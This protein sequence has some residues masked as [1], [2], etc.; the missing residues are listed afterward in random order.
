MKTISKDGE[1]VFSIREFFLRYR[2][3]NLNPDEI[4]HSIFIPFNQKNE[5]VHEYKQ[6][7]RRE[8]D[9][10]IVTA[11]IKV[12][13]SDLQIVENETP[14][15]EVKEISFGYGGMAPKTIF[16]PITEETLVGKRWNEDIVAIANDCLARDLPLADNAP[17][18]MIQ[19]R[20][21]LTTSFFFKFYLFVTSQIE[22]LINEALPNQ[23]VTLISE[24]ELSAI[25]VRE[26]P[27]SGGTQSF[28][29]PDAD[30]KPV[31]YPIKHLAADKQVTGEAIY[32]VDIPDPHGCLFAAYVLS[33]KAHAKILSI[34]PSK[35]LEMKGVVAFFSAKDVPKNKYSIMFEDEEVFA[36]ELSTFVGKPIG[37]I[38]AETHDIATEAAKLVQA[39]YEEF[40]PIIT[41]EQAIAKDSF[42]PIPID[43]KYGDIDEGF[44]NS[45]HIV[46]GSIKTG[47]Q[48]HFYLE[49]HNSLA[50]PFEDEIIIYSSTQNPTKNQ[51]V[52]A[53]VLD[54]PAHRV[55]CICKRM[56]GG[57][58]GKET[59]PCVYSAVAA[60]AATKLKRAVRLTLD[61]DV[62]MAISGLRHPFLGHYKVGFNDDGNIVAMETSLYSNAGDTYDLSLPVLERF[63]LFLLF[64]QNRLF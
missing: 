43:I 30:L 25:A 15:C 45:K 17:G 37:L 38:V 39:S 63:E 7:R 58:G 3:V 20:K 46:E 44:K 13:L 42:Y 9:I 8:D 47:A 19:F 29:E 32:T 2:V 53:K 48:D 34:D 35:A 54:I 18:G 61:R 59:K 36:S 60:F 41:I 14:Y 40:E 12:V 10:A 23:H 11:G 1:R 49:T 21:S 6:A 57:F 5:F 22:R 55:K 64:Y 56:G 16:C 26:R 31:S 4:L 52:T 62:D 24:R 50:I 33:T 51:L 28:E 27:V